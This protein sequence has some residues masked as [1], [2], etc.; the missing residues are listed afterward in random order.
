MKFSDRILHFGNWKQFR[1]Y[2][3]REVSRLSCFLLKEPV[4]L[5]RLH[6][7]CMKPYH[8]TKQLVLWF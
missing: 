4:S 8:Y 1:L 5:Q 3:E 2:V 7:M 6:V